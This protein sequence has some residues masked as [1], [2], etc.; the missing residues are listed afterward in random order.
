MGGID[1]VPFARAYDGAIRESL[2]AIELRFLGIADFV[3]T[4]KASGRT[5]D[6]LDVELLK[7][8]G[9]WEED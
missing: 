7:E 8:A 2:S 6:L 3:T 5:E 1:G 4:K 9:L